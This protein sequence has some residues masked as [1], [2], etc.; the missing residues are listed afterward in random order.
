MLNLFQ[1]LFFAPFVRDSML[2]FF[3]RV[4]QSNQKKARPELSTYGFPPYLFKF[5][6]VFELASLRHKYLVFPNFQKY[7]GES[8]GD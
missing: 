3:T 6:E 5:G 8:K 1:Y 7:L 4:K 2:L